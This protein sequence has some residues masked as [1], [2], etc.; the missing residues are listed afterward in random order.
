MKG[1]SDKRMIRKVLH[2]HAAAMKIVMIA[3][4]ALPHGVLGEHFKVGHNNNTCLANKRYIYIYLKYKNITKYLSADHSQTEHWAEL[5]NSAQ[6][7]THTRTDRLAEIG[8][9]GPKPFKHLVI[10]YTISLVSN[11]FRQRETRPRSFFL[12]RWR[13]C[14]TLL[15]TTWKHLRPFHLI[16]IIVFVSISSENSIPLPWA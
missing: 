12:R 5:V 3:Q 15:S 6:G 8:A 10:A 1:E 11:C 2:R 4:C 14:H 13:D 9:P 7:A 16:L